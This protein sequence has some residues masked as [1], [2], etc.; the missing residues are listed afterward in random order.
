MINK[1]VIHYDGFGNCLELTDGK[2]VLVVTLDF[3]PRIIRY[4]F[5]GGENIMFE[6]KMRVFSE[7]NPAMEKVY[8]KG[9]TWYIYGGHRFWTSPENCPRTYYPD[10]SPVTYTLTDNGAVFTQPVQEQN[11]YQLQLQVSI[12]DTTSEVAVTH[13]LINRRN[14]PITLAPWGI[15]PLSAGGVLVAP[16]PTADT[17]TLPNRHI[18]LW[19][20]AK[21]FDSRLTWM[22]KYFALRQDKD[23]TDYFKIGI[24]SQHGFALYF[25]HGD[26]FIKRFH[27]NPQGTYSDGGMSFETYVNP[28]FL[29]VESL[30]ELVTL[31]PEEHTNHTEYWSLHKAQLP[32]LTDSSLDAFCEKYI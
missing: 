15:S 13:T 28:L 6:D 23:N 27:V 22:E 4:A 9:A 18:T 21:I 20:K 17:Y 19:P 25:N 7:N 3:G 29:E 5:V 12:D 10:N 24:N 32:E 31:A 2:I 1:Q 11:G 30:G 14:A 26:L 16:Q 8:G